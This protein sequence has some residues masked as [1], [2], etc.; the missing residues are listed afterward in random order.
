MLSRLLV[1]ACLGFTAAT[2]LSQVAPAEQPIQSALTGLR[3]H[4]GLQVVLSGTQSAGEASETFTTTLY[5]FESIEDGRPV[6]RVEVVGDKNAAEVFRIVGDGVTLWAYDA[7]RNEYSATRYGNYRGAQPENYVNA[8]LGALGSMIE[9]RSALPVRLLNQVYGGES[10]RYR[11]WL[12]GATPVNSGISVLYQLGSPVRR[13]LEF[14]YTG[15]D[16]AVLI[17]SIDYYDRVELGSIVRETTW[18]ISPLSLD[19]VPAEA[20]FSFVPPA[21]SRAIAGVRPVTTG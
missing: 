21:G 19:A 14:R 6:V 4:A 17:D 2:A 1:L 12:P 13:R 5:W 11:S 20:N 8:L 3:T 7:R 9:G 15:V 10:A 18:Q 16:P